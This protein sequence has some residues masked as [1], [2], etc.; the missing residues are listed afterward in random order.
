MKRRVQW[1]SPLMGILFCLP[2]SAFAQ[3]PEASPPEP[4]AA[5]S[6]VPAAPERI[7]VLGDSH[8]MGHFG[9]VIHQELREAYSQAKVTLVAACGKEKGLS[10]GWLC[11]LWSLDPQTQRKI[12]RPRDARR[13]RAKRQ[14]DPIAPRT[15]AVHQT[16]NPSS[17]DQTGSGDR[18]G[19]LQLLVQRLHEAR[20]EQCGKKGETHR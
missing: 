20:V 1:L 11:P 10:C 16:S 4:T 9:R 7:L 18:P 12:T 19:R 15:T 3:T 6:S 17:T 8:S 5:E 2:G 14:M 13:I